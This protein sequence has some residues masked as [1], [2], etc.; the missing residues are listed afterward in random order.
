[1]RKTHY[2]ELFQRDVEAGRLKVVV[3]GTT[4]EAEIFR[5]AENEKVLKSS[6]LKLHPQSDHHW[7]NVVA[8]AKN[9][10]QDQRAELFAKAIRA[11]SAQDEVYLDIAKGDFAHVVAEALEQ[12][13]ETELVVPDYLRQAIEAVAHVE[14]HGDE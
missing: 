1:M 13:E 14:P 12:S 3:G 4:L 5:L 6:F 8:K 10:T 9:L 2:E 7:D 11:E